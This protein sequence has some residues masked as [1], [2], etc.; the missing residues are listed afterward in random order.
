MKKITFYLVLSVVVLTWAACKKGGNY[1][2]GIISPYIPLYDLRNIYKGSD[3]KLTTDVMYG[4][5]QITGIVVSDY[6]GNNMPAGGYL[7]VQDHRRLSLLRGIAIPIGA[8]AAAQYSSGDSVSVT[9]NGGTLTRADGI[10]QIKNIPASAVVKISSGNAIAPNRVPSSSILNDPSTYEST[11]VAIVK[12]GFDP[13]PTPTDHFVGDKTV[14]DGFENITL[15]TDTTA[16]F[17]NTALPITA[18]FYGIVFTKAAADGKLTPQIRMRKGDDSQVLSSVIEVTSIVIS[19]FINDVV[20]GDGNYEYIQLLATRDI[21]FAVTPYSVVVTNNAGASVPAGYPANGWATGGGSASPATMFRTFKFNLTTG[22]AKKGTFFYVG[23]AGKAINGSASTTMTA[24]NWIRAFDYT[25][26]DGDGF[27]ARNGGFF[28]NSGNAFGMAVFEGTT[29][30]KDTQPIDVVFVGSGGQLFS[31]GPPA[32]GYK[33]A[34]T[35]LYDV[36]NPI[37]LQSQPYYRQGSNTLCFAYTTPADLGFYYKLGGIYNPRL[38]KWVKARTQTNIQLTKQSTLDQIEA[39]Y[40]AGTV[41][42]SLK[43]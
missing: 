24:S 37:T 19:G 3:V 4:S 16:K 6:S 29:V 23:G 21:D 32:V 1:P 35:D 11:L 2:G 15:H 28:A 8:A 13:L 20:G 7:V 33:I 41:A 27:G 9:V 17:A 42:T 38:G 18:N 36:I 31:A 25:K 40:P 30:T 14:N 34:N 12:G 22:T 26:A 5:D 43:N 10:L 39:E